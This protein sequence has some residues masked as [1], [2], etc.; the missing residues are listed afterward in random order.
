MPT[1]HDHGDAQRR[2]EGLKSEN[3]STTYRVAVP[4]LG[5]GWQDLHG[6][7]SIPRLIDIAGTIAREND[8][9]LLL[10]NV[11]TIPQPTP[12]SFAE[13]EPAID[14]AHEQLESLCWFAA[15]RTDAPVEGVVCL[16][17]SEKQAVLEQIEKRDCDA[18]VF[19]LSDERPKALR[20]ML[21]CTVE[22]VSAG[23]GCDVFVVRQK[24]PPAPLRRI[25]LAVSTGPH[26]GL[27]AETARVF[28][29]A[30]GSRVDV[31]HVVPPDASP[32]QRDRASDLVSDAARLMEELERVDVA[33]VESDDVPAEIVRRSVDYDATILGSPTAGLLRQFVFE[34]V[35]ETVGR[36]TENTVLMAKQ[37]PED[38]SVYTRWIT[39]EEDT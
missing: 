39:G 38:R 37:T 4:L 27:A 21:G 24:G 3:T 25:L 20:F 30:D 28:G 22:T 23:A 12:L 35:P 32:A 13:D 31:I 10:L 8:G 9:G 6:E 26:S 17:R 16:T 36:D 15:E 14:E 34:S 19:G 29:R 33:V 2:G 1:E 11:I 5:G 18:A 7:P